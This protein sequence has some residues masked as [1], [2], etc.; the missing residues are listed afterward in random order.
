MEFELFDF[1][2]SA[3]GGAFGAA[4]GGL[5]AFIFT[6]FL[7]LA[8]VVGLVGGNDT[9]LNFGAFGPIFG[10]HISFAGAV[11]AAVYAARRGYGGL[12]GKDIV[13]PLI[14]L[15]R[16]DVL[17][18]GGIF[19][20]FGYVLNN[21]VALIPWFGSN[22]DTIAFTVVV[23]GIVARLMFG[24]TGLLGAVPQGSGWSRFAP[25]DTANWIRYHE[26]PGQATVLG[27]FAGLAGAGIAI[28][29]TASF[30]NDP[31]GGQTVMFG[32]S[33]MSLLFLSLGMSVPVT[34]HM[35]LPAAVAAMAFMPI[36]GNAVGAL[37]MGMIFGVLGALI[38]EFF[39]R[40]WHIHGD[41][42]IDPPAAAIWPTTTL[43]LAL[44]A[45]FA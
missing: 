19:G 37:V 17:L 35:T 20:M 15:G 39:S 14:S 16:P 33:A 5:Q 11:A 12:E 22:T 1:L 27:L 4:I 9:L 2:T 40:L 6:G 31:G 34:H 7:V 43:A 25:T 8:G 42:H 32:V 44:A 26:K 10:P 18:V 45:A 24:R 41:S 30:G 3:G 13:T 28:V 29:F 38:G 23:S 21:I 36:F